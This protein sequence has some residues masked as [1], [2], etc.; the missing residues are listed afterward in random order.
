MDWQPIE[1]APKDGYALVRCPTEGEF[2]A[3]YV[4]DGCWQPKYAEN[5]VTIE[6]SLWAPFPRLPQSD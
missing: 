6:P 3:K 2:V 4:G 5:D 1:T